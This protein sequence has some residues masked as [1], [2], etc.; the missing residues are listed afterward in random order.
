[1]G[2]GKYGAG[3]L[4]WAGKAWLSGAAGKFW[5]V[6]QDLAAV[7]SGHAPQH[8]SGVVSLQASQDLGWDAALCWSGRCVLSGWLSGTVAVC[9]GS[10]PLPS[11]LAG[12][13]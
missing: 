4:S 6:S 3:T 13:N 11:L 7:V 5:P 1:M 9:M 2:L 12:W 8:L 10:E